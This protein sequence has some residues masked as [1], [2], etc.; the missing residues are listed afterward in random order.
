MAERRPLPAGLM[1]RLLSREA[2]AAYCGV[3]PELFEQSV[4]VPPIRCFGKRKL[5]DI[6]A[7][8]H[9]LDRQSGLTEAPRPIEEWLET[10]GDDDRARPR[11]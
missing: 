2:A 7:L 4:T 9:W 10:L 6:K 1:P 11:R 8:D 3:G 5:W